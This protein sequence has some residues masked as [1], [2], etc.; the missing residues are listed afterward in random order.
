[1]SEA[2]HIGQSEFPLKRALLAIVAVLIFADQCGRFDHEPPNPFAD[3]PVALRISG[4]EKNEYVGKIERSLKG[5]ADF[6]ATHKNLDQDSK[7][8]ARAIVAACEKTGMPL[9]DENIKL[10]LAVLKGESGFRVDPPIIGG[11]GQ[12][13]ER[14]M[15]EIKE[16]LEDASIPEE[17]KGELKE[18]I[19]GYEDK[20]GEGIKEAKTEQELDKTL[21]KIR[22]ELGAILKPIF[23]LGQGTPGV[24]K[25]AEKVEEKLNVAT[26]GSMQVDKRK[27]EE[28]FELRYGKDLSEN[29]VRD[30]LFTLE[31]G[32]EAGTALLSLSTATY[33][34]GKDW[35]KFV[36]ADYHAGLFSSRNAG[37]Q[38]SLAQASGKPLVADGDLLAYRNGKIASGISTTK[39]VTWEWIEAK[40]LPHHDVYAPMCYFDRHI[41]YCLS[42]MFKLEKTASFKDSDIYKKVNTAHEI[43]PKIP[44]SAATSAK[45]AGAY[46]TKTYVSQK[47]KDYNRFR[48]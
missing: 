37:F 20:Y 44:Q 14:Y 22:N 5:N 26:L 41:K 32:I 47:M 29:E 24:N 45:I 48:L 35:Q 39:R 1:M 42:D 16:E 31:G 21:E 34:G 2:E 46:T 36:F 33:K 18:W 3:L 4:E 13:Y 23:W 12:K 27:A 40:N 9:K 43:E 38:A 6:K 19:K 7:E 17:M 30:K 8:W 28:Y 10:I 11:M 15:K 25:L